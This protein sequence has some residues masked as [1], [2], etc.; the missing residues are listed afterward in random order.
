MQTESVDRAIAFPLSPERMFRRY[1]K[2]R[3]DLFQVG[4]LRLE[5]PNGKVI[6]HNGSEP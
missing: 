1:F 4:S 3:L 5:L 6:S 2:S